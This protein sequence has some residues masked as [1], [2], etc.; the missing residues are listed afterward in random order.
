MIYVLQDLL[1]FRSF[2]SRFTTR[3][4]SPMTQRLIQRADALTQCLWLPLRSPFSPPFHTVHD[5]SS[6]PRGRDKRKEKCRRVV[7]LEE[8]TK[9]SEECIRV[10]LSEGSDTL[11]ASKVS[12]RKIFSFVICMG[13]AKYSGHLN[14]MAIVRKSFLTCFNWLKGRIGWKNFLKISIF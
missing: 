3:P 11:L 6:C 14:D 2:S 5:L 1:H 10:W 13:F 8:R 7:P 9:C 4:V 12:R